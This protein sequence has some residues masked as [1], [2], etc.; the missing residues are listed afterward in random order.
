MAAHAGPYRGFVKYP[1]R[2]T[3]FL[4]DEVQT[5]EQWIRSLGNRKDVP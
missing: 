5:D 3:A 1:G 4:T 2:D